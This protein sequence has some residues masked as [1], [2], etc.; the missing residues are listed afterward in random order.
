V[1]KQRRKKNKKIEYDSKDV[2]QNMEILADV[3]NENL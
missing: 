2:L 1:G 3:H